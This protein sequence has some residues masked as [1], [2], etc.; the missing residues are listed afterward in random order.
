MKKNY[1]FTILVLILLTQASI[2]QELF[3]RTGHVNVTSQNR[4]KKVEADNYQVYST[5]NLKTG[6]INFE[7]LLKSFEFKLGAADRVFN[8]DRVNVSKYPKI[9]F[10]GTMPPVDIDFTTYNETQ[11][12]VKGILYIWDEQRVTTAK[13]VIT[14]I[15]DGKQVF[16]YSSFVMKIEKNSM[17]KINDIMEEKLPDILS[18][19]T[20]TLGISR[21]INVNLDVTYKI[22]SN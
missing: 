2:A 1:L 4:I 8:S 5:I 17:N 20:E 7:G 16:A 6:K 21:D 10:E 19:N 18:V 14:S 22:K 13:A 15:G 9:R 11:V 12:D 3:S